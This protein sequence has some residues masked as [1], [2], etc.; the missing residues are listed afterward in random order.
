VIQHILPAPGSSGGINL[1]TTHVDN[2]CSL[3][4]AHLPSFLWQ[5]HTALFGRPMLHL[6]CGTNSPTDLS[7]PRQTQ[8]PAL[9]PITHGCSSSSPSSLSP[10]ASALTR[11]VLNSRLGP[12]AN[13][14]LHTLF[15]FLPDWL[16]GLSDHL[17]FLFCSTIVIII[18]IMY[19]YWKLTNRN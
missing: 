14:F 7:E 16:H 11:S 4:L 19:V 8:S 17:M 6:V 12:S 9:L 13:H 5:S 18:I 2:L 10:L 15:P 3:L 1:V